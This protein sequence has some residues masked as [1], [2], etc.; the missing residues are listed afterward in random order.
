[1]TDAID[2]HGHCVPRAFLNEVLRSGACGVTGERH[3]GGYELRLPGG[4]RL[5]PIAGAM[6]DGEQRFE[7]LAHQGIAHQIVAPWLDVTGQELIASDGARWVRLLNDSLAEVV[8]AAGGQLS[9]HATVHLAD[10]DEAAGELHRCVVDLGMQ[11]VM[12]P[13]TPPATP[14]SDPAFD[15]LWTVAAELSV[16]VI[17]HATTESPASRML[18][19]YPSLNGLFARNIETTLVTADLLVSGVLDRFPDLRLVAVHG[20]GLLPYQAGRFAQDHPR[21]GARGITELVRAL[22]YDTV[23]LTEAACAFLLDVVGAERVVVG[24]DYGATRTEREGVS[25]T[26][27]ATRAAAD[28]EVVRDAV[29]AGNA[30]RLFGR[31]GAI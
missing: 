25:V 24:S 1:M 26:G 4:R 30:R 31:A 27:P 18:A 5:R 7:W 13:C 21:P 6:L 20:G 29:L 22:Y 19:H 2:I 9:A 3:D 15:P 10:P 14:L 12:L 28:S 17:L 23:L 11:G 8:A 16:P